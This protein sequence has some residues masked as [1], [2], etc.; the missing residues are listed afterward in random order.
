MMEYKK[1]LIKKAGYAVALS[2]LLCDFAVAQVQNTQGR[3][4]IESAADQTNGVNDVQKLDYITAYGM[5][6]KAW[7]NPLEHLGEGQSRPGYSKYSWKKDLVLPIRLREGMM[8]L[9]NFPNWEVVEEVWIGS[10]DAFTAEIAS[11]N[12]LML[13]MEADVIGVDSNMIVFGRSGN[14]YAF[15]LRSEGYNTDRI[16]HSLVDVVVKDKDIPESVSGSLKSSANV[17][18][19]GLNK[20]ATTSSSVATNAPIDW[21]ENIN[22]NPEAFRFDIDVFVPNPVDIGWAPERVWRDEIFTYIDLGKKALSSNERPV[23][24]LIVQDSEVPVGFRTRGPNGRLIVVEAVGDLVLRNGRRLIC[25]KLRKDP[26]YGLDRVEYAP[27]KDKFDLGGNY[28]GA[29]TE[30]KKS[31]VAEASEPTVNHDLYSAKGT[32]GASSETAIAA[33]KYRRADTM[34]YLYSGEDKASSYSDVYNNSNIALE[35]GTSEE[36]P[37]LEALWDKIYKANS[38]TLAGI[39]PY[40]SVDAKIEDGRE[41]FHLRAGP[42][43]EIPFGEHICVVLG[44]TGFKC[45]VIKTQ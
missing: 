11:P 25:L 42:I 24:N 40:F 33:D 39:E 8:T 10:S 37:E 19:K 5:Q 45:S 15:Y 12:S 1:S 16:T 21:L 28:K 17:K 36:I 31:E 23:V 35:L 43:K 27:Q 32:N 6:Q 41:M 26:A 20:G 7:N 29:V 13:S 34:N 18:G 2:L 44:K 22:V 4:E 3:A 14:R 30:N 38:K 9:I